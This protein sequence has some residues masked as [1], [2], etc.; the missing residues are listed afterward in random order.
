[1]KNRC[2]IIAFL[3]NL[4]WNWRF[5]F[6]IIF[7]TW[8]SN[9][10]YNNS[11]KICLLYK[12]MFV[13]KSLPTTSDIITFTRCSEHCFKARFYIK[14]ILLML[15]CILKYLELFNVNVIWQRGSY[16]SSFMSHI[17]CALIKFFKTLCL[18]TYILNQMYTKDWAKKIVYNQ[19][20]CSL[21]YYLQWS[22]GG[23]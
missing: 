1:M 2:G 16:C 19:F 7:W 4:N 17:F 21:S 12:M 11:V 13:Q 10:L 22:G 5:V 14:E 3:V 15:Y 8:S 23:V 20:P 9:M 18:Q 6:C